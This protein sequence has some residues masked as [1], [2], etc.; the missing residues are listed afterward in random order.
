MQDQCEGP[1]YFNPSPRVP[2]VS[3]VWATSTYRATLPAERRRRRAGLTASRVRTRNPKLDKRT[4]VPYNRTAIEGGIAITGGAVRMPGSS[5][6]LKQ[7]QPK[8]HPGHG[9]ARFDWSANSV[10]RDSRPSRTPS[11]RAVLPSEGACA[12]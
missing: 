9:H 2:V 7:V 8:H 12:V 5:S 4:V 6:L 1:P 10:Q 3:C 11:E